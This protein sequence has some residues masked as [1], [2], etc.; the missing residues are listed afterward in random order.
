MRPDAGGVIAANFHLIFDPRVGIV[1]RIAELG[2]EASGPD[3]IHVA[4]RTC[5]PA[6]LGGAAGPFSL[7][8]AE[9][10]RE[11]AIS[12]AIRASIARYS[13]ALYDRAGLPLATYD[14][15]NFRCLKPRDFSL[16]SWAQYALPGFP[17]VAFDVDTPVRWTSAVDLATGEPSHIPA[18][19]IWY[20]YPYLRT[21]GDLPIVQPTTAGLACGESV[22]AAALAG[23]CDVIARD[24]LA[25]FWQS[26]TASPR[27]RVETLPEPIAGMARRFIATGDWVALLDLTTNNRVPTFVA[28]AV[29]DQPER[30]AFAFGAAAHL[31][32]E[33]AAAAAFADLAEARRLAQEAKRTKP[34][35]APANDW[36]DVSGWQDHLNFAAD[37]RNRDLVAFALSSEDRRNFGDYDE[38]SEGSADLDLEACVTRVMTAGHRAYAANLT[39]EDVAALGLAVV[40][41]VVPGYQQLFIG[42]DLRALGG[43]RI[44]DV[45]PKLGYRG[46]DRGAAGNPAPHP[47]RLAT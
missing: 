46:I 45:P 40:R 5:D 20:P 35:P 28:V 9:T 44:Y 39:S 26:R 32:P 34:L 29:S 14:D 2:R 10:G 38:P 33:T 4:A 7:S 43:D 41:V 18:P 15:A 22:A 21:G 11:A 47:F 42:H 19:F 36:E 25:V 17:F 13:A 30:P 12:K 31:S 8:V 27:V 6:P 24:S 37:H 1:S 16:Y 3:F 23:L